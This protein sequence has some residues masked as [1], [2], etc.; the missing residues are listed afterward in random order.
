MY[1]QVQSVRDIRANILPGYSEYYLIP[2]KKVDIKIIWGAYR[3]MCTVKYEQTN[4][5]QIGNIQGTYYGYIAGNAG[6]NIAPY[7]DILRDK[8]CTHTGTCKKIYTGRTHR[9]I[10]TCIVH[11]HTIGM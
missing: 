6:R 5:V 11:V 8:Y 2:R 7:G 10:F 4:T 9:V 1:I 3:A